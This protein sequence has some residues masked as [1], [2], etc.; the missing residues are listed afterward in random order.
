MGVRLGE[1]IK[2]LGRKTKLDTRTFGGKEEN[3]SRVYAVKGE[4]GE[5]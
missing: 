4:K 1:R 3:I 2:D 5:A